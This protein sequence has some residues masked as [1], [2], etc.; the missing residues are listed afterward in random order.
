MSQYRNSFAGVKQKNLSTSQSVQ[1]Q[2]VGNFIHLST[3]AETLPAAASFISHYAQIGYNYRR[4][5]D[6]TLVSADSGQ[7]GTDKCDRYR[8][9]PTTGSMHFPGLDHQG[10]VDLPVAVF[11]VPHHPVEQF[12]WVQRCVQAVR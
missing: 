1:V 9:G 10:K 4:G 2:S 6:S 11:L 3:N 7:C 8:R 12:E 5:P